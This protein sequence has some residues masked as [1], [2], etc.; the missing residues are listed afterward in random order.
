[1]AI[2]EVGENKAYRIESIKIRDKKYVS[3]RQMYK[4]K[5]DR[6]TWKPGRQGLTIEIDDLEAVLKKMKVVGARPDSKFKEVNL[7]KDE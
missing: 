4:T 1:M 3:V 5:K 2:V 6:D 7:D